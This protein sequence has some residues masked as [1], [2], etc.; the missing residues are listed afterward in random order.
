MNWTD[1]LPTL[2]RFAGRPELRDVLPPHIAIRGT[3]SRVDV[4][5]WGIDNIQVVN[6]VFRESP[7]VPDSLNSNHEPYAEFNVCTT[8]LDIFQD[9][10]GADFRTSMIGKSI[11]VR[12]EPGG[13]F[14]RALR[15]SIGVT[16]ARQVRPVPSA[17][18]AAGTRAWVPPPVV[19]ASAETA[20]NESG[21]RGRSCL[22]SCGGN[23]RGGIR[24]EGSDD[25]CL[26]GANG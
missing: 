17:Q 18:F 26:R 1:L 4:T 14:C 22:S 20:T 15:G 23:L 2:R 11:E 13:A 24:G 9:V 12:G 25:R 21:T 10:F 7:V 8:S 16:L 5:P 19:D 3:V 6:V